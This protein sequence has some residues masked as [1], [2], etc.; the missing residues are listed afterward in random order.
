MI[1]AQ[2]GKLRPKDQEI[3]LLGIKVIIDQARWQPCDLMNEVGLIVECQAFPCGSMRI[4]LD[5]KASAVARGNCRGSSLPPR[6]AD[7]LAVSFRSGRSASSSPSFFSS[8][9]ISSTRCTNSRF[10]RESGIA[11]SA[12]FGF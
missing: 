12:S 8:S 11:P 1:R 2:Q 6:R 5:E 3:E 9:L 7:R 4:V 10:V